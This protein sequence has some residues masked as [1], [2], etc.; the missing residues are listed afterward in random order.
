MQLFS[1][2]FLD[3]VEKW[4]LSPEP[5]LGNPPQSFCLNEMLLSFSAPSMQLWQLH[6]ARELEWVVE[7]INRGKITLLFP[8]SP[9]HWNVCI[10]PASLS[11]DATI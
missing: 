1:S 11:L 10:C 2:R 8:Y 9:L 7:K 6:E 5:N 4:Q 3:L